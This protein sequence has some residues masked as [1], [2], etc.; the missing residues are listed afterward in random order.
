VR[1][2]VVPGRTANEVGPVDLA[3]ERH[4]ALAEPIAPPDDAP[5]KSCKEPV[6]N[7]RLIRWAVAG[8]AVAAEVIAFVIWRQRKE[9]RA[10]IVETAAA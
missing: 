8:I 4:S 3:T 1:A 2:V 6:M 7:W 10:A 5:E 9:A